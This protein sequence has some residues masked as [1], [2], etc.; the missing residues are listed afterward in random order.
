MSIP[1]QQDEHWLIVLLGQL[2][3]I[4]VLAFS[5]ICATIMTD[6]LVGLQGDRFENSLS[7]FTLIPAL[8][9]ILNA[10]LVLLHE[11]GHALAAWSVGR[12]VHLIVVGKTGFIP[13][14]RRVVR[15]P[16]SGREEY[17]GFVCTSPIWPD[18]SRRKSIWV[19]AGGPLLTGL[20][21]LVFLLNIDWSVNLPIQL[22]LGGYFLS[23]MVLNLTP[24][25]WR[26]GAASDGLRIWQSWRDTL[27]SPEIWAATRVS[28][29]D[30]ETGI[31]SNN[32]WRILRKLARQPFCDGPYL[33]ELINV[34]ARQKNDREILNIL[35][36]TGRLK[37]QDWTAQEKAP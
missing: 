14:T 29:P 22:A 28:A 5:V 12:R 4:A 36:K 15:V 3:G 32:E 21:G 18:F 25:K 24:L 1:H 9:I 37:A 16:K 20:V 7:L 27:W 10:C 35:A 8:V 19:S 17:A 2:A 33:L 34:A 31:V 11:M 13:R 30:A 6:D 23:D 26:G